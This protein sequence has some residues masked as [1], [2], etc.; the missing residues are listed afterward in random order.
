MKPKSFSEKWDREENAMERGG[1]VRVSRSVVDWK[2]FI[3]YIVI[4]IIVF[5]AIILIIKI[6]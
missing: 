1:A 5:I 6:I 2:K 4:G 3:K